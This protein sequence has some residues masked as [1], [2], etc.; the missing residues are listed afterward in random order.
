GSTAGFP[1]GVWDPESWFPNSVWEPQRHFTSGSPR[2]WITP[3][4]QPGVSDTQLCGTGIF[5]VPVL[6]LGGILLRAGASIDQARQSNVYQ[7]PDLGDGVGHGRGGLAHRLDTY[8]VSPWPRDRARSGYGIDPQRDPA[9]DGA[10]QRSTDAH[11]AFLRFRH[12]RGRS[13]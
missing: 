6:L 9:R 7:H 11:A 3:Q 10:L 1:N 13:E 2:S 8:S 4:S 12:G 5:S